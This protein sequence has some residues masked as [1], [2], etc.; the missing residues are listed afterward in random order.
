MF[1][2]TRSRSNSP[3]AFSRSRSPGSRDFGIPDKKSVKS[4][5]NSV[6]LFHVSPALLSH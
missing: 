3:A 2:S 6:T 1:F 4:S 5:G